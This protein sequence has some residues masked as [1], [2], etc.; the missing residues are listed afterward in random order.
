M[1][2]RNTEYVWQDRKRI[3]FG[4]PWTFTRYFLTADKLVIDTGFLSRNED[5][6]RLYRITDITLKRKLWERMCGLGTIHCCSGDKTSPEFD[7]AH[8]KDA[9]RVKDMLSDMVEEARDKRR[10]GV[11]EFM[12][13]GDGLEDLH[14]DQ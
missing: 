8:V 6:I 11:R 14:D 1:S 12:D 13:D 10:V 2:H 4:L 5:D 3:L 9:R 7:I